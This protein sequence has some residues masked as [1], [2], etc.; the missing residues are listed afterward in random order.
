MVHLAFSLGLRPR[1][2]CSV[3]L[4]DIS[5]ERGAIVIPKRKCDNPVEPPLPEAAIKAVAAYIIGARPDSRHRHLF[6]SLT[7]PYSPL[8]VQ[9]AGAKIAAALKPVNPEATAYWL[10]HTYAQ[11]MLAAGVDIFE[12]KENFR[13]FNG[14]TQVNATDLKLMKYPSREALLTLCEWAMRCRDRT[15]AM[16][17]KKREGLTGVR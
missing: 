1:E 10:R 12:V 7:A 6:L 15:Q 11:N 5:F 17:G 13:R 2:I 9:R 16:M 3:L 8:S 14:H 4:D